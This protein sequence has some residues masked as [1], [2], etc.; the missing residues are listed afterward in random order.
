VAL[1]IR[2]RAGTSFRPALPAA[3][4]RPAAGLLSIVLLALTP[5]RAL[6]DLV[7]EGLDDEQAKNVR[8]FVGLATEPCD[9]ESWVIRRRFRLAESEARTALEP[10]GYYSPAVR[11]ELTFGEDCWRATLHIDPGPPVRVR[12]LDLEITG[13]AESDPAFS[14]LAVP[15]ALQAGARLRHADYESYK[16]SLQFKALERGYIEGVFTESRIDVWPDQQAADIVLK[17]DSGPRY[18]VG[19]IRQDQDFL[20]PSLVTA[21]LALREGDPYDSR[22]L[23][24]AY[25]DLSLTGYF[26]RIDIQPLFDAAENREIPIAVHLEPVQRI[27]YTV[28]AG[29]STDTGLRLRAGFR[30]GR[31]NDA[32][33]R[34]DVQLKLSPV[35]SGLTSEYRIPLA[36][37]RSDWMSYNG[38]LDVEDTDTSYS[39]TARFGV[40]RSKLLRHGLLRT[41]GLDISYERYEVGDTDAHSLLV[42][43]AIK[44]DH[45][46]GAR[47]LYPDRGHSIELEVRGTDRILGSDT[48]FLQFLAHS[49]W[50]LPAGTDAR[51]LLRLD[52]G[53]TAK[54]DFDELPPSVRFFAGGDQSIRG[55]D[56]QSL[57]PED[58]SGKVIGGSSLLTGS[59]EYEHKLFGNYYGAAFVD[60]GNAFDGTDLNAVVGAGIG[61]KWRSPIGPIR[62]YVAHPFSL[63]ENSIHLHVSVGVE[64]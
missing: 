52:G 8:A 54:S 21:V 50:V 4:R 27:E 42:L 61:I 12:K 23:A 16:Q 45:K 26:S 14:R 58:D 33:H 11:S 2:V 20:E 10:Y 30:N 28:G 15:A 29:Y 1:A 6:A 22:E 55:Y 24:R 40:R 36:D 53:A 51:W 9:A 32:G 59:I 62:F 48:S 38:T 44:F 19:E 17:F 37:P 7:I 47:Q 35:I 3:R 18:R 39:E 56:Y 25:E 41:Y 43:P 49:R 46:Y 13:E 63:E 31:V 64:L 34:L 57:G 60:A 5:V